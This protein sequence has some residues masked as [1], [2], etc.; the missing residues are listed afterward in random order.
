MNFE[1]E[2][3]LQTERILDRCWDRLGDLKNLIDAVDMR[4]VTAHE[5]SQISE[6]L[7]ITGAYAHFIIEAGALSKGGELVPQQGLSDVRL[8]IDLH[9]S[10]S[11]ICLQN[12]LDYQAGLTPKGVRAA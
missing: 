8:L 3:Q 7:R 4:R 12:L 9:C 11:S 10:E 6:L 1:Y 5:R 2:Q